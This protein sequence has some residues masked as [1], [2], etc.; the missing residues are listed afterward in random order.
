MEKV[1]V[2]SKKKQFLRPLCKIAIKNFYMTNTEYE[3]VCLFNI[4]NID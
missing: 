2:T 4:A 3:K 1:D